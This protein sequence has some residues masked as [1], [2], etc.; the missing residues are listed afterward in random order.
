MNDTIA[1]MSVDDYLTSAMHRILAEAACGAAYPKWT[2]DFSMKCIGEAW[3]DAGRSKWGRR[4]T[5]AELDA[6]PD[7]SLRRLGFAPWDDGHWLI[8][9]W[10]W[11]YIAE[12]ERLKCIDG[13]LRTKGGP[14]EIDL[15][16]R[17][18]CI[19]W[20]WERTAPEAGTS[21]AEHLENFSPKNG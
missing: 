3:A 4:V 19:A 11:N 15:D 17:G 13:D 9:L 21:G 2:D 16:V 1:R 18:G 8:P 5:V 12:G 10:A 20:G 6:M 7:A 14:E